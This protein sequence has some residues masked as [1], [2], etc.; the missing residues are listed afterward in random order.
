[1]AAN[2]IL[3]GFM[4]AGNSTGGRLMLDTTNAAALGRNGRVF[5]LTATPD[6]IWQRVQGTGVRPLLNVPDPLARIA[7]LLAERAEG[8]G[9]YPQIHTTGRSVNA[10]VKEI[11]EW[12]SMT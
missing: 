2:I 6:E 9:R 7:Q 12:Y 5:C 4:G 10:V 8:Y 1:M 3:T 11:I